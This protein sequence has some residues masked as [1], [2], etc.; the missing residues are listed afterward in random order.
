MGFNIIDKMHRH[1]ET[2]LLSLSFEKIKLEIPETPKV[3]RK[4]SFLSHISDINHELM[5]LFINSLQHAIVMQTLLEFGL[6]K[7]AKIKA[8][9]ISF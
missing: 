4:V 5:Q 9:L 8:K 2:Q 6:V 1:I 7:K 3:W